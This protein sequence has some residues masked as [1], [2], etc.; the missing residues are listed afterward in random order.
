MSTQNNHSARLDFPNNILLLQSLSVEEMLFGPLHLVMNG[1]VVATQFGH[2]EK[3][4]SQFNAVQGFG[5]LHMNDTT[6]A[7]WTSIS[8]TV[9]NEMLPCLH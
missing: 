9:K 7:G 8:N 6:I 2:Y 4:A 5:S 3:I 1:E